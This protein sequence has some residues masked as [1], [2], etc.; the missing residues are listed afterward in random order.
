LGSA[1]E[2][3][4]LGVILIV[5]AAVSIVVINRIAGTR[6]DGMFGSMGRLCEGAAEALPETL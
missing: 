5:A 3:A 4:A 6:V 2:A 1:N